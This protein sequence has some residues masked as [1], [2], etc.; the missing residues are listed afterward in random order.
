M[1]RRCGLEI[2]EEADNLLS[3]FQRFKIHELVACSCTVDEVG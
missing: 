1:V 3:P 2:E